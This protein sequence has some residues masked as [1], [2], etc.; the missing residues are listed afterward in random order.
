MTY[1]SH[2]HHIEGTPMGDPPATRA[3]CG[4][5][6]MC[7]SCSREA[8]LAIP[9]EGKVSP[10][11]QLRTVTERPMTDLEV[12]THVIANAI[13]WEMFKDRNIGIAGSEG[14]VVLTD[15]EVTKC[16]LAA[17]RVIEHLE[18]IGVRIR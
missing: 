15:E 14:T 8:A 6:G 1:T 11:E 13:G 12:K 4:G 3:R 10:D 17:L 7:S 16:K 5:P 18:E 9:K 2:G